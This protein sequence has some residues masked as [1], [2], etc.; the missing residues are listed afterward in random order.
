MARRTQPRGGEGT[1]SV[2][3]RIKG[4]ALDIWSWFHGLCVWASVPIAVA[5]VERAE[6]SQ[7]WIGAA[8]ALAVAAVTSLGFFP[9]LALLIEAAEEQGERSVATGDVPAATVLGGAAE[10]CLYRGLLLPV[11]GLG[12]QALLFAV[13]HS[14]DFANPGLKVARGL[15]CLIRG[16]AYGA[17]AQRYGV[18]P[19]AIGVL[20]YDAS[21]FAAVGALFGSSRPTRA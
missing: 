15:Q 16:L 4:I 5:R 19:V 12:P 14:L 11:I 9:L 10:E 2:A 7:L 18:F 3:A 1:V 13:V 6:A 17:L 20:A 8:V 21:V